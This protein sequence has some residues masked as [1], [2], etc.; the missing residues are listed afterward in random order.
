MAE[1]TP[2]KIK[3]Y[4]REPDGNGGTRRRN[5]LKNAWKKANSG[6]S[7]K[8]FARSAANS[9]DVD[10]R[11]SATAWS[12]NKRANTGNPPLGIGNTKK[13]KGGGGK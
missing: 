8:Q 6:L 3:E 5:V 10:L 7:L 2:E 9:K 12:H 11:D 4:D 13:K 1:R